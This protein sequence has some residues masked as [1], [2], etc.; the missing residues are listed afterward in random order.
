MDLGGL[1][2]YKQVFFG[3][4]KRFLIETQKHVSQID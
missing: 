3:N 4:C 1:D 2:S